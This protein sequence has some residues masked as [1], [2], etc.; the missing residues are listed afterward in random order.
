MKPRGVMVWVLH[1]VL[2]VVSMA[3]AQAKELEAAPSPLLAIDRNR[4]T[5][6]DRVVA[7]WGDELARSSAGITQAQLREMLLAM[8]ADQLLAASLVGNLEG[9]RNVVSASLLPEGEVKPSL[10][11][12]K[13]LGDANQDVTY[14]PVTPCRL[15]ETRG[16]F[17]AVYQ[18]GGSFA[19]NEIRTY[20]LQGGNGVCLSQLPASISPS[21][22]Q[23]QVYGIPTTTGSGDI[24]ILPQGGTF[25]STATLVY[26]GNNAFTSASSTSLANLGNKQIS[27]QV[28]GGG[29]HV[30]ID[31]VGYFRP[32]QGGFVTSVATGAGLT[33]G[34]ITSIG[35][36]NLATTQLLPTVACSANQIAKWN[37]GAWICAAD[38]NSGGT[39]TSVGSGTG[40][41]GGPITSSGTLSIAA[42]FQLPQSC[43]NGQVPKS[44]GSGG[45]TCAT[46]ANSGGTVTSITAG[47]GLTGGTIT[48]SGTIA[49]DPAST[50]LTNNFFKQGGNAF[51]VLAGA[52]AVLGTADNNAIDI[53]ANGNRVMRYEPGNLAPNIIGGHPSNSVASFDTQTIAGGGQPGATCWNGLTGTF[54]GSCANQT[55]GSNATIS[56][57]YANTAGF[58]ASVGG[59][60]ANSAYT[61]ATVAGGAENMAF[62]I[63]AT[64]P[65]GIGNVASGSASFAAGSRAKTQTPGPSP[66]IHDGTFVWADSSGFDFNTVANREFAARATGGVRFVTAV[67]GGGTP[68]RTV[69]INTNGELEMGSVT[70]QMLNLY[71]PAAYGI[72]VQ[73]GTLY[74]RTDTSPVGQSF[75]FSWYRGGTH[76]DSANA[77]G[78]G[79]T[80]LMRLATNGTLYVTGG[81]VG[82]LSDRAAKQDFAQIDAGG[83]LERVL[84]MP[85]AEWSYKSNPSV[86]HIGPTSQDFRAAFAVG[87]DDARSIATVDAQGVALAAIQGLNAKLEAKVAEQAREIAEL[88][89]AV[90]VLL[91]RTSPEGRIAAR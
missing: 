67:D 8:R 59:G 19:T 29:A 16:T 64:V 42:A 60:Y 82:T 40:L 61:F 54:D 53:R 46:D 26:L 75:G 80:E 51:G 81:T 63:Y 69:R 25:G 65:G 34:P 85:V 71:G 36:I 2:A 18:G 30:A 1:A 39:V 22:V 74:F 31:V 33:G 62:G 21:A 70:R 37:G 58:D 49:V 83:V 4:S 55:T 17:A 15:V 50:T 72:G 23:M 89:H 76:S 38:A 12:A 47:N 45:W 7:Q 10:L 90:E 27:V 35:T 20:T 56:G 48:T 84:R 11:H 87:D 86:R 5:V 68:T 32:P 88:K 78:A 43:T 14:V 66:V 44:N 77:P 57:G 79:G 24:E 41:T 52:T 3:A 6:V 9:L 73:S 13:A 28:R 91:A